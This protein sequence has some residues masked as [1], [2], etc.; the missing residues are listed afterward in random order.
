MTSA[1]LHR[2][3]HDG[4]SERFSATGEATDKSAREIIGS[5]CRWC[6]ARTGTLACSSKHSRKSWVLQ[7]RE[8][9]GVRSRSWRV[10]TVMAA[11]KKSR[12]TRWQ[13]TSQVRSVHEFSKM[14]MAFAFCF[15]KAAAVERERMRAIFAD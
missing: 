12:P 15:T 14:W 10:F 3:F 1:G 5:W 7:R 6:S 8:D 11:R 2:T 4:G 9:T 13:K